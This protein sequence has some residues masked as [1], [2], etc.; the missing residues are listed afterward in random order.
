MAV[1]AVLGGQWGDEG[2]GKIVDVLAG[3]A[4]VIARCSGGNNAG[5]TVKNEQGTFKF[6]LVP[7]GICWPDTINVIGNGVV[8]DPEV[9]LEEL[10][11]IQQQG[12]PG[13]VVVS[14]RAHI[15]MP[16]HIELDR[17]EEEWRGDKAIGTTKSGIGPAYEDKVGRR[18]IRIGELSNIEDLLLRL[19]QLI[20]YQ[21][22][23]ITGLYD[24]RP[25]DN[26]TV[27]ES[28]RRW[29]I[30]LAPSVA[31][32]EEI[33]AAAVKNE[34][35]VVLEGAQGMLLDIDHGT[36]PFVTASNST[37]GG[38]LAGLGIGP[39]RLSKVMGVFKAYCTRVGEGPFPTELEAEIAD[40]IRGS[41]D[42]ADGEFGTST[43][44]PR[45]IGW[46]DAVAARHSVQVNG[47][48]SAVLT[49]LDSLDGWDSI[50]ICVAYELDGKKI[51]RF[52]SDAT[53]LSRCKPIYESV[54]GWSGQTGGATELT[55]LPPEA[56]N[57]VSRLEE[58]IG[59]PFEMISTGPCREQTILLEEPFD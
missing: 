21:N 27:I 51:T 10:K 46:F 25:V 36:Y 31:A 11:K 35:N 56:R 15:I 24:G 40:R 9:L 13:E 16:Y 50:D 47:F 14:D 19:P 57:Y 42:D 58:L 29:A 39:A 44:R 41:Q 53:S 45:R 55:Q 48:D 34:Q 54:S 5:H 8:V 37:A 7:S 18:G 33:V 22:A 20:K 59:I 30:E 3:D 38:M 23:K 12:L 43:G 52:P 1:C 6:H 26:E 2:K 4:S 17:A 32:T 28:V 49:R